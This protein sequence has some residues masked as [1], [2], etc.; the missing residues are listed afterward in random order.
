MKTS[1][2]QSSSLCSPA[3]TASAQRSRTHQGGFLSVEL[4][5]V[6]LVVAILIVGAVALYSNNLRQ[7]SIGSNITDIQNIASVAKA[8]YGNSNQYGSVTTAIAVRSHIVPATL[9]NGNLATATNKFGTAITFV[10]ANGTGTNDLLTLTW[11]NVP[12]SQ[13]AE[14]VTG[15]EGS[16]RRITVAGTVV[17]PLDGKLA[18]DTLSTACEANTSD[19]NVVVL[20][21]I[22]R[23]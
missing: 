17:K 6:L 16:M 7:T 23:S 8:N 19:G 18:V 12:S 9:R 5:L 10:S 14:I 22:G 21:D 20:F 13:C 4:G 11:G 1:A 3:S 2:L 15:S